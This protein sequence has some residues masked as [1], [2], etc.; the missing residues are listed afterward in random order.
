MFTHAAE[1]S[2]STPLRQARLAARLSAD[3]LAAMA[4]IAPLT[5][6]RLERGLH[7]PKSATRCALSGALGLPVEVLFPETN[8]GPAASRALEKELSGHHPPR[9]PV[10][11]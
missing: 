9:V 8:E 11:A 4:G 7:D 3:R 1:G 2:P 6:R 10:E 5:V